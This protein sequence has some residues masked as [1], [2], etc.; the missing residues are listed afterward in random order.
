MSAFRTDELLTG[1]LT[2]SNNLATI[3]RFSFE[4]CI[5]ITG[6]IN[7]ADTIIFIDEF[8][9]SNIPFTG[10]LILP[11]NPNFTTII[12]GTF[13]NGAYTSLVIPKN[14][15]TAEY[16]CFADTKTCVAIS[17]NYDTLPNFEYEFYFNIFLNWPS[18]GT[19]SNTGSLSSAD[20]YN[21]LTSKG[22]PAG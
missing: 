15:T 22:L 16:A 8:A 2:F 20:I 5:N 9:F 19:I 21:Y 6:Q 17:C 18:N 11:E 12:I 13:Q 3:G 1:N 10:S 4:N 7:F 14:I